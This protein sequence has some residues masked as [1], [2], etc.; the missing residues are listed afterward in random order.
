MHLSLT[1]AFLLVRGFSPKLG[2]FA[3]FLYISSN[4]SGGVYIEIESATWD[5]EMSSEAA[6]GLGGAQRYVLL[7]N[8]LKKT[9]VRSERARSSAKIH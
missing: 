3:E 6:M 7:V 9:G 1:N 5:E 2:F 8:E 4:S